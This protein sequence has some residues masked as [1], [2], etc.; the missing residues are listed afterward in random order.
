VTFIDTGT[1]EEVTLPKPTP[2]FPWYVCSYKLWP[3][4]WHEYMTLRW[5]ADG[6]AISMIVTTKVNITDAIK[7]KE[8]YDQRRPV[9]IASKEKHNDVKRMLEEVH[10]GPK[11]DQPF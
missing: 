3:N 1:G 4:G 8:A 5:D 11:L 9:Q 2:E 7:L 6:V 10:V